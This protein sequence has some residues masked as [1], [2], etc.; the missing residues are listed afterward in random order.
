M[1]EVK[2][3]CKLADFVIFPKSYRLDMIFMQLTYF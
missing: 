3:Q 2:E 1:L